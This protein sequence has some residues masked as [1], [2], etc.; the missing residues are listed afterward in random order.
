MDYQPTQIEME[1]AL[2]TAQGLAYMQISQYGE[3]IP[4]LDKAIEISP[5]NWTALQI[6]A[7]CKSMLYRNVSNAHKAQYLS[8]IV[9]DLS[10]AVEFLSK[11]MG[12]SIDRKS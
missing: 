10:D 6:R 3:A 5:N 12:M 4:H 7:L 2:A 9:S 11:T 8:E 1:S